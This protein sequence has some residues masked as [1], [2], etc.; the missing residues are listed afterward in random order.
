M[1][2]LNYCEL[3]D[4][5]HDTAADLEPVCR[6]SMVRYERNLNHPSQ[7]LRLGMERFC[8]DTQRKEVLLEDGW[9]PVV[10]N[11]TGEGQFDHDIHGNRIDDRPPDRD[12]AIRLMSGS[13]G[14]HALTV[15]A[16]QNLA[17]RQQ[18]ADATAE[19]KK[20]RKQLWL[21]TEVADHNYIGPTKKDPETGQ[22]TTI[23]DPVHERFHGA[24]GDVLGGRVMGEARKQ[25]QEALKNAPKEYT[26][27]N[28]EGSKDDPRRIGWRV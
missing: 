5:L 23:R 27:P 4:R 26:P 13:P 6:L 14:D 17:L 2:D 28:L 25:M 19:T 16:R 9:T 15:L 10:P 7:R 11:V 21:P 22:K 3:C 24:V 18:L 1:G 20:L 12:A 8:Y